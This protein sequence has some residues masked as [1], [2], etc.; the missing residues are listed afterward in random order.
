MTHRYRVLI[1]VITASFLVVTALAQTSFQQPKHEVR[2][3]WLTTL[4]GLDWP[5]AKA[6]GSEGIERQKREL[7]AILNQ[8]QKANV[9]TVLIQTRVRAS[10]IYPSDIEPWDACLTGTYNRHPGY[11]PLQF[12]IDECHKRGMELHAWVV[13]IP[14][15]KWT[16]SESKRIRAR[17]PHLVKKVGELSYLNPEVDATGDYIADICEEIVSRYDVDGI[18]L[19]YIRYPDGWNITVSRDSGRR[20]ITNIVRKVSRRVKS[21]KPWVKMSC[22]PVGKYRD[23]SRY[24]SKGWNAYSKVCQ[25]AQEWLR[26][27]LMDQL[28]PMMYFRGDNYYPFLADWQE[29]S[30]GRTIVSGLGIWY[31]DRREGNWPLVDIT[32]ELN[33]SRQ[34]GI[35]HCYFR[36]RFLT[37]NTKGLYDYVTDYL[38]THPAAIPP[39]TWLNANKPSVPQGL[40]ISRNGNDVTLHWNEARANN[41]SP[42]IIYNVYG[43]NDETVDINDVRNL[44]VPRFQGT[45]ITLSG[46]SRLNYAVTAVDRYG[47]ESQPARTQEWRQDTYTTNGVEGLLPNDG[48]LL[49][50]PEKARQADITHLLVENQQGQSLYILP[51]SR[52]LS[53]IDISR[54]PNGMYVLRSINTK[55]KKH[56]T[57]RLGT[58]KKKL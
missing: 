16:S 44:I 50:L 48:H 28:Y 1:A 31:L 55:N 46:A 23:L 20:Y 33:V 21:R 32:R 25:P 14:T 43:C 22:S 26:D 9:N 51:Y 53:T 12:A 30:Y 11:D 34:L 2:A 37:D 47:N 45:S 56:P 57:H 18:H 58:F 7:T 3:V 17:Y 35:G 40:S 52:Y 19:D 49:T 6:T 39:A 54:L 15:G 5:R 24:S 29:H 4:N 8:L 36:S 42:T 41:D 10:V 27:G 38:D 13:S